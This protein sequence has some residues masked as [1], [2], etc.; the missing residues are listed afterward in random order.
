[1]I[2]LIT[3]DEITL[4]AGEGRAGDVVQI[5][6]SQTFHVSHNILTGKLMRHRVCSCTREVVEEQAEFP[7]SKGCDQQ[8]SP[9]G[10]QTQVMYPRGQH[11][12]YSVTF[13]LMT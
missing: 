5:D 10:G 6:I 2:H 1:M 11:C 9:D 7:G 8:Q 4:S 13:S 12:Q 3:C